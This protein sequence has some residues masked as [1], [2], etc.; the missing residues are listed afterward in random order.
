MVN[1]SSAGREQAEPK[2]FGR[3]HNAVIFV[4]TYIQRQRGECCYQ[5]LRYKARGIYSLSE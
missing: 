1:M 5:G 4:Y 2:L 3:I